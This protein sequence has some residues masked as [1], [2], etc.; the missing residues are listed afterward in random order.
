[1]DPA[2]AVSM[3]MAMRHWLPSDETMLLDGPMFM[4][5]CRD[6]FGKPGL[7]SLSRPLRIDECTIVADAR[8]DDR[9]GHNDHVRQRINININKYAGDDA[10]LLQ[11]YLASGIA[12][13]E[14]FRGDFSVAIFDQRAGQLLLFR[15]VMGIRPLFYMERDGLLIFASEPRGILAHPAADAMVD[16]D[17]VC[18]MLAGFPP[19]PSSTF[20][21][22]I[23]IVPPGHYLRVD[24]K[25]VTLQRY[26]S[27]RIPD[28][29]NSKANGDVYAQFR[30]LF[31]EA[32]RC[33]LE[34]D[35]PIATELSGGLDSSAVTCMAASIMKD[36]SRLHVFSNV[37]PRD[38]ET[39]LDD[40]SKYIREVAA[41]ADLQNIHF[42][43][44][45]CRTDFRPAL[46]LDLDVN[47][48]VEY[49]TSTWLE[50]ARRLMQERGIHVVLSGWGGDHAVSHSGKNHWVDLADEGRWMA[51]LSASIKFGNLGVPMRR[52]LKRILPERLGELLKHK[53]RGGERFESYLR[54]DLP[55]MPGSLGAGLP[56]EGRFPY[57]Q[58]LLWSLNK[59]TF[60]R[61]LQNEALYGIRHRITP[62][63]PLLDIRIIEMVLSMPVSLLGH[64]SLD[65]YFFRHS[66]DGILPDL[67]R[68]RKDKDVPAGVYFMEENRRF[69]EDVRKWVGQIR[70][71]TAHPLLKLIDF[72]R[73][74]EDLNPDNSLNQWQ[75]EFFPAMPFHLQTLLRYCE[76]SAKG[77]I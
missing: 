70:R 23:R 47:G 72:D 51:Y 75:G 77:T 3:R 31:M 49:M 17:F 15:D 7:P 32:V 52:L 68:W 16:E 37:L 57:K 27:P 64:S 10:L 35:M 63:Y 58:H 48:G 6:D 13:I 9:P 18:R 25:S 56:T 45:S 19:D 39:R 30:D 53:M 54:S 11:G 1:M 59:P 69:N 42:I 8:I 76:N 67:V 61:R 26:V 36:R 14:G 50:P 24:K 4:G 28:R 20:H 62:R 38:K 46:D 71:E 12:G 34:G 41:F 22:F 2:A 44:G 73:L 55:W 60:A 65:R 40:E 29:M 5:E 66:M 21:R 33:R 43:S 74:M